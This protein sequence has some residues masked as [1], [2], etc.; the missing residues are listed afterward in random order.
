[1]HALGKRVLEISA[2]EI[3]ARLSYLPRDQIPTVEEARLTLRSVLASKISLEA[4]SVGPRPSSPPVEEERAQL[5]NGLTAVPTSSTPAALCDFAFAT[6]S[7]E[8]TEPPIARSVEAPL[9]ATKAAPERENSGVAFCG[10]PGKRRRATV[11]AIFKRTSSPRPQARRRKSGET[12]G[13]FRLAA[14]RLLKPIVRLPVIT[15]AAGFLHDTFP[16]LHLWEWNDTAGNDLGAG[17]FDTDDNH[18]SPHP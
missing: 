7:G 5:V 18:P 4:E 3:R 17:A 9:S 11:K 12:V 10:R 15:Y 1:M 2:T 6:A 13:T 16:W 14:R 8:E